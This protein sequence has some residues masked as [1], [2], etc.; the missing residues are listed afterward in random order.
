LI[1]IRSLDVIKTEVTPSPAAFTNIIA[2]QRE[3]SLPVGWKKIM[4]TVRSSVD[5]YSFTAGE[6]K[7][8]L[9]DN[10]YVRFI[11]RDNM[12]EKVITQFRHETDSWKRLLEFLQQENGY[13]LTRLSDEL[14]NEV[15]G[16]FLERAEY[17]QSRFIAENDLVKLLRKDIVELD[18]LLKQ[19]EY[20]DGK[21]NTAVR[22]YKYL[23]TEMDK[24]ESDFSKLKNDFTIF[25]T[26][27]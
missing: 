17:Y 10:Y 19:E 22:K 5:Y 25:L 24:L 8:N 4:T 6:N 14:K 2:V 1:S 9:F 3:S 15:D 13:L 21:I 11:Q 12:N 20:I 18:L 26:G 27:V 16:D 7:R 23:K